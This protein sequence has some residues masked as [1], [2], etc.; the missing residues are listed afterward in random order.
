M[1]DYIDGTLKRMILPGAI[2]LCGIAVAPSVIANWL[3][4]EPRLSDFFGPSLLI[5]SAI[6]L[7]TVQQI[8]VHLKLH[9]KNE[10][11]DDQRITEW[12]P[13]FTGETR[14]EGEMVRGILYDAEIDSIV[15]SNRV[16]S[17]A[18][19]LA[20]W[21][22]SRPTF[23][24]LTIHRRLGEGQVAVLVPSGLVEKAQKVLVSQHIET[25]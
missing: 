16:I 13:V 1:A 2:F 19:T 5:T 20:L 15:F 8:R 18:G 7:D 11:D 3:R 25:R 10:G 9:G 23:P 24:S 4:V 14:I 22:A 17:A 21:E 6:C 12:A